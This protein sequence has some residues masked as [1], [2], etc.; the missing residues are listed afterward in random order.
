M[1]RPIGRDLVHRWEGNPIIA[2]EDLNLRCADIHNAGIVRLD[3]H[4]VMLLTVETLQG[5]TLIHKAHSE[6]GTNFTVETEPFLSPAR[7][8]P[9]AM[10]ETGGVRDA[11]ITP[12]DDAYYITYLAEGHFGWRVGLAKTDDFEA[13]EHLGFLTQPDVKNGVLFPRKIDG[14][15]ALLKRPR[16]RGIWISYS[17]DLTYWGEERVVMTPR[18][19]HWDASRIGPSTVPI[20]TPHGW[21][22]VYYGA[23]DTSAGPLYR[24][25][26]A[27]LD[28]DDPSHVIARSNVPILS[29]REKYE[30]VGDL[31]NMIFSCGA[32]T[33]DDELCIYYGGSDSCIC[34]GTVPMDEVVDFCLACAVV[35]DYLEATEGR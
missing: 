2:L 21:L 11:R 25:G 6:D 27:L 13:V 5:Y 18:G 7:K 29:P 32:V 28:L 16:G 23:K 19:G 1:R 17:E 26:A 12:L 4:L 31:P 35:Q 14:K 24:L 9:R 34:L 8:G 22:L 15:Y 20:H 33:T 30:R 10:Y 3:G